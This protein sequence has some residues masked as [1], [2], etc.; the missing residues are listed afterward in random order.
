MASDAEKNAGTSPEVKVEEL[1]DDWFGPIDALAREYQ[2]PTPGMG[3]TPA[4]RLADLHGL[5]A[6]KEWAESLL[7]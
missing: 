4:L 2:D 6:A 7:R 5:G 3:P 1:S